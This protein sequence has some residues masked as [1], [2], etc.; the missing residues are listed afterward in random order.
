MELDV[1]VRWRKW[2]GE[3]GALPSS[4]RVLSTHAGTFLFASYSSGHHHARCVDGVSKA[5]LVALMYMFFRG[6][7]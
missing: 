2:C 5:V 3:A 6:P 4:L 7:W 1:W